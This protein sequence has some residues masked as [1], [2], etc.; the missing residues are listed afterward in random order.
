MTTSP[1]PWYLGEQIGRNGIS[2]TRAIFD[3]NN[4][5]VLC[6]WIKDNDAERIITC[7]NALVGV[8]SG[9][10]RDNNVL[11]N[12]GSIGDPDRVKFILAL[13]TEEEVNGVCHQWLTN[14]GYAV[15]PP[16]KHRLD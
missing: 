15:L 7:V 3:A 8:D 9:D 10:I 16:G 13:E 1:T 4:K 5:P 6:T 14:A 2:S 11:V 12:V